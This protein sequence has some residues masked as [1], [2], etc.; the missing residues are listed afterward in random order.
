MF[1]T[2]VALPILQRNAIHIIILWATYSCI[3]STI[4]AKV[5]FVI[6]YDCATQRWMWSDTTDQQVILACQLYFVVAALCI[7][8][9]KPCHMF[10]TLYIVSHANLEANILLPG[11]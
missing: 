4:L 2:C 5:C 9:L 8:L 3:W 1:K 10:M 6:S 7:F 11:G